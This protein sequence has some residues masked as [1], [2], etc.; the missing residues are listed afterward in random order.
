MAERKQGYPTILEAKK[1]TLVGREQELEL[2]RNTL[3]TEGPFPLVSVVGDAGL[4]KTTLLQALV[5]LAREEG[6]QPIW[7]DCRD[8]EPT[9]ENLAGIFRR[10]YAVRGSLAQICS[11]LTK[12][13][14]RP[15][16]VL[17]SFEHTGPEGTKT[18]GTIQNLLTPSLPVYVASRSPLVLPGNKSFLIKLKPFNLKLVERFLIEHG[19]PRKLSKWV[20]DVTHGNPLLLTLFSWYYTEHPSEDYQKLQPIDFEFDFIT[21]IISEVSDPSTLSLIEAG[22]LVSSLTPDL[23]EAMLGR[24]VEKEE[25]RRLADLSFV[26]TSDGEVCL[27]ELVAGSVAGF[28]KRDNPDKYYGYKRSAFQYYTNLARAATGEEA[29]QLL[30]KRVF[31]C[32]NEVARLVIFASADPG[33]PPLEDATPVDLE[34]IPEFWLHSTGALLNYTRDELKAGLEDTYKLIGLGPSYFRVLRDENGEL[35]GYHT[36]LP[37]F[38]ETL[39][40]LLTSPAMSAYFN[41]LP[42][43]ELEALRAASRDETDT[44]AIRHVVFRDPSETEARGLILQDA[45]R[46]FAGG[47]RLVTSV[48]TPTLV[49]LVESM[50]F[51]RVE[52]IFDVTFP[53]P[54]AV[55][56]LD[57]R[58]EDINMWLERISLIPDLPPWVKTVAEM[59][60]EEWFLKIKSALEQTGDL[61]SLGRHPLAPLGADL[62][63]FHWGSRVG[64]T[65]RDLGKAFAEVLLKLTEDLAVRPADNPRRGP[66]DSFLGQVL[67]TTYFEA[68]RSR[69]EAAE[70]LNLA[71]TTYYRYLKKAQLKLV[72]AFRAKAGQLVASIKR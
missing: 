65:P 7:L 3:C 66:S 68:A 57:L 70:E 29:F 27:H 35:K 53:E 19:I 9:A 23:A 39:P 72:E 59:G 33:V 60:P 13:N 31:L 6:W 34:R 50:G 17:D 2:L 42:Q 47:R 55:V 8:V 32:E 43:R 41:N 54:A 62:L 52:G 4:G 44:Y 58:A 5:A 71:D 36:I 56:E 11:A 18:L 51:H 30:L 61:G 40:Y 16:L 25:F 20:F 28:M 15:L 1:R 64:K 14:P 48:P 22:C 46:A 38:S 37:A 69:K 10:L 21:R 63:E 45:L 26:S 67:L 24:V 49:I 12:L